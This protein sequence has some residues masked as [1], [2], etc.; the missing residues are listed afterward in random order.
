MNQPNT[1]RT[2][3]LSTALIVFMIVVYIILQQRYVNNFPIPTPSPS[4]SSAPTP[5]STP[6]TLTPEEQAVLKIPLHSAS[7]QEKEQ[8]AKQVAKLTTTA[9]ELDITACKPNPVVYQVG[10]NSS[11]KIKNNDSIPHTL[12]YMSSQILVPSMGST[13]I[14]TSQ[15]FKIAGDYGYGCDNPFAKAGVIVVR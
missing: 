1:I 8:H 7:S 4:P 3:T 9:P 5:S 6:R 10:L 13:T 2:I 14:K 11:F 15:L 12:R